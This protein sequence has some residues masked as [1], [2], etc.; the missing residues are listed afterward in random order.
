MAVCLRPCLT[1][2]GAFA[3]EASRRLLSLVTIYMVDA[4]RD[5]NLRL[6]KVR[7]P[8]RFYWEYLCGRA[9]ERCRLGDPGF[10]SW[11]TRVQW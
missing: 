3:D 4:I 11:C 1:A 6:L 7:A 8:R 10:Q 9:R 5:G 2:E